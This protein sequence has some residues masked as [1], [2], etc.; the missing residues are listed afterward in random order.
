MALYQVRHELQIVLALILGACSLP[1]VVRTAH[2][3]GIVDAGLRGLRCAS[4]KR[5]SG[6][7]L[8]AV[9]SWRSG[10]RP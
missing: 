1:G 2:T 10:G 5:P 7:A 4:V 9:I 6:T 3:A 8:A